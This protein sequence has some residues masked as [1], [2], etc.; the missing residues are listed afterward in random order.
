MK[1]ILLIIIYWPLVLTAQNDV[2]LSNLVMSAG[3]VTFDVSWKPPV[4]TAKWSDTAWVFVDYNDAGVRRRLPLLPGATLTTTPVSGMGKVIEEQG[5]N[6]GVWVV[7]STQ[8]A[9]HF[10]ASV[11]LLTSVS[12][13]AGVCAYV[14]NDRPAGKYNSATNISFTGT[15][16]YNIV[17][18]HTDGSVI[19]TKSDSPYLVPA[20]YTLVSFTDATGMPGVLKCIPMNGDIDFSA[21]ANISKKQK[22]SFAVTTQPVAPNASVTYCW[23]AP[24]FDPLSQMGF[25]TVFTTESPATAGTYLVTVTAQAAGY[26]SMAKTKEV[27][28]NNCINPAVQNLNVSASGFCT[29]AEGVV[30]AMDN[31]QNGAQYQLYKDGAATGTILKG[32][33]GAATFTGKFDAAGTY[34]ARIVDDGIYCEATM[35]GIHKITDNP[36]PAAPNIS[37][38]VNRCQHT[39]DIVFTVPPLAGTK[40]EWDGGGMAKDNTYTY[41]SA[42]AGAKTVTVRAVASLGSSNCASPYSGATVTV[43]AS[44]T[45]TVQPDPKREVCPNNTVNLFVKAS[46]VTT[47]QWLKNG[48]AVA[49]GNGYNRA[50]YTTAK[51]NSDATYTVIMSSAD[52]CSVTSNEAAVTMKKTGCCNAPGST[53]LF[54]TFHP[55]AASPI[56]SEWMLKDDRE[57]DNVQ[58]YKVKLLGDG[59]YWIV[60]NLKF[61]KGCDK[62]TFT[63]SRSDKT[64]TVAAG[65]YGDCRHNTKGGYLYNWAAAVNQSKAYV[66]GSYIGCTGLGA[67][68]NNCQGICPAG[69][70]LP[71]N[72]EFEDANAKFKSA[73]G[74]KD[75]SCWTS[76]SAWE[77]T[78]AGVSSSVGAVSGVDSQGQYWTSVCSTNNNAYY[79]YF[80]SSTVFNIKGSTNKGI[81][82]AVRCIRNY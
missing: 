16:M 75:A 62:A 78:F 74:C 57:R 46:N 26:C 68:A 52:A 33:G 10:S 1:K 45:I 15:P 12:N 29:G 4:S 42:T 71:T 73:Y 13:A 6:N 11:K 50:D 66:G 37:Q 70:H 58:T 53:G 47:Y 31:T 14:S 40:Y 56:N 30:F 44:P 38:P 41:P 25:T 21:P 24:D 34:I 3:T 17:L 61:G 63:A 49:E 2:S 72:E 67:S 39:G 48:V 77:T 27:S 69:W 9:G 76:A 64:G 65:Y 18:K 7:G 36:L 35:N 5:N 54:T 79:V 8:H 59:R 82:L 60:Q 28:L 20:N 23:L 51:L 32:M 19:A 80:S 81:G 55:C 43:Y 22:T